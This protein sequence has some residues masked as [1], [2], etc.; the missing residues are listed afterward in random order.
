MFVARINTVFW[1]CVWGSALL[2]IVIASVAFWVGSAIQ[3][4]VY[5]YSNG[6]NVQY[7]SK[8]FA[9]LWTLVGTL[10]SAATLW[11]FNQLLLITVR[12][13]VSQPGVD[14]GSVECAYRT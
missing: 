8:V 6:Y 12:Q 10:L 3:P 9:F 13:K 14:I 2:L 7:Y 5:S 4:L 1:Q 11:V